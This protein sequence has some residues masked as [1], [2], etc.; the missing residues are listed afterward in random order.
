[1]PDIEGTIT[2]A[3]LLGLAAIHDG[4]LI[5][6]YDNLLLPIGMFQHRSPS[7]AVYV[8]ADPDTRQWYH[9]S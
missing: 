2:S 9:D 3:L 4:I 6:E 7:M 8:S 5:H 1:M